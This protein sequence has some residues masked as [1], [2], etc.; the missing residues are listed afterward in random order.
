MSSYKILLENV[1]LSDTTAIKAIQKK[2]NQWKT[3]GKLRKFST[4]TAGSYALFTIAL[5]TDKA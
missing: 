5:S 2:L 4:V 3:Q 1:E